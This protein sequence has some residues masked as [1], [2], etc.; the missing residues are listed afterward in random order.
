[1][2]LSLLALALALY[3]AVRAELARQRR[4]D[5]EAR[6]MVAVDGLLRVARRNVELR[7]RLAR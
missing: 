2:T 4:E 1:M 7:R 6:Y 5:A 3:Y